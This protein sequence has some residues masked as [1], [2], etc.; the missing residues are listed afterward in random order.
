M[1]DS[2][3]PSGPNRA[4]I[5]I[6]WRT[7]QEEADGKLPKIRYYME[8]VSAAGGEPILVSLAHPETLKGQLQGLDGFVLPGSPADVEPGEY[9]A[10]NHGKSAPADLPRE[11][12]DRAILSHAIE[13]RKPVLAICYGCQLLNV[14]LGGT[15]IQDLRS[16]TGTNI[17]HRKKD[18]VPEPPKDPQHEVCFTADSQLARLAGATH[19]VVNSSHHQSIERPG[20][21]LRVTGQAEDGIVESVEWTGD[22]NWVVGVQ[23]HPE[24]MPGD[25]LARKLFEEFVAAAQA[26]RGVAPAQ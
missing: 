16:E 17:A 23:W 26:A 8:A 14:Y 5:G 9:G 25:A 3:K 18:V 13:S 4:R 21:N 12:T 1:L 2:M 22:A 10:V 20:R 19:A 11:R 7:S 24:R 6:P 15:L